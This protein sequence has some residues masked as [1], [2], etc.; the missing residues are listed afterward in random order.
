MTRVRLKL[1][2]FMKKSGEVTE[3]ETEGVN[4]EERRS[5]RVRD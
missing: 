5:D 3:S 1:K 4:E 2:E